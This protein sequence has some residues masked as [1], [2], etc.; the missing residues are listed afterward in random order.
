MGDYSVKQLVVKLTS[1]KQ[2]GIGI[3]LLITCLSAILVAAGKH[4]STA[5]TRP[6]SGE[7]AASYLDGRLT[8]WM[9]W[10]AAA[11]DHQTFCV[12]CHTVLPYAMARPALRAA[13][14]QEVPSPVEQKLLENVTKR[15]RM[16]N[17][18]EPFYPDETRGVPKT[19]ESRGTE[20]ILNAL[21]LAGYD[22]RAG[23]LSP[24]ARRA[25]SSMWAQQLK[26]GDARGA[27]SW[28]EF[29]NSPWEGDSQFYGATL[30][31]IAVGTAPEKYLSSPEIQAGVTLL[32]EYLVRERNRQ[33][34]LNRLMLLWAS[35]K[36]PGVLTHA[37]QK[38]LIDETLV[39]QRADGGFSLT[40]LVGD[41]KRR[42]GTA[43]ETRSDGYATGVI[44]FVLQQAGFRSG[45]PQLKRGLA[46][47]ELN[48]DRK[49]GRWL[50]YSLNKQ[51]DLA[52]DVGRF[53]SDAATA[54]AVLALTARE[55]R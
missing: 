9:G 43:L 1:V 49:D 13:L 25:F 18:V 27:W 20:S 3:F 32:R 29:H 37:Q 7:A 36:L 11:R 4:P 6:W 30:A 53:M 42:D 23:M 54:Y 15:V 46:W 12:S 10:P 24:E 16:W 8:W 55:G 26:T 41:W 39:K 35:T 44:T 33:I 47:L 50:A 21:I 51:R 40:S 2:P 34:L 38:T 14:Q 28:L 5:D 52:S 19:A 45:Q 48:Q 17:E 31:A 22:A